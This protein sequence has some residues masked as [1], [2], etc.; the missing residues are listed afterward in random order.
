MAYTLKVVDL[1]N[2]PPAHTVLS[3]AEC[4]FYKTLK[5]QK[6]KAEWL[7]GRLALK[8]LLAAHTGGTLTDFTVLAPNG[9]G[10]PS[11]WVLNSRAERFSSNLSPESARGPE[12]GWT[13]SVSFSSPLEGEDARRPREGENKEFVAVNIPFSLTHSNGFAVAALAPHAQAIGIDLEVVAPRISAWKADFFHPAE[14]V[15]EDDEFLTCLWTQKEALVKL[16]GSGLT[17]NSRDVRVV[18]NQPQFFGRALEMYNALGAPHITLETP[19][20]LPGFCFSVALA[21]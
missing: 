4:A 15:R 1:K 6:R 12:S 3:G 5:L 17:V 18:D 20:L 19:A 10:K 16:L 14:L 8:R 7:G 13:A 9:V 2:L 11:A 21:G